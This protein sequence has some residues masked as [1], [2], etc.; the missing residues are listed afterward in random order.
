MKTLIIHHLEPMWELGYKK[1]GTSFERL[2][3]V[4]YDHLERNHYNKVI[5]TRFEDHRI[6]EPEY[7]L[8]E[9][10][11]LVHLMENA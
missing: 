4:F 5:L 2:V 1:A 9:S 8:I 10:S 3:E 11:S 6:H 7:E